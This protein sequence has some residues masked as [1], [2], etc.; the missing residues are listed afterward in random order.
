LSYCLQKVRIEEE[1][2]DGGRK[3][4]I[5]HIFE[6]VQTSNGTPA[7]ARGSSTVHST[8]G[9]YHATGANGAA[10][11][12]NNGTAVHTSNSTAVHT[13]ANWNNAYW[14]SNEYGYWHVVNGKHVFVVV[15]KRS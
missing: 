13:D 10:V 3:T 12:T 1:A 4:E 9:A 7:H 14:Q 15:N 5:W 11:H 6:A 2:E 8:N